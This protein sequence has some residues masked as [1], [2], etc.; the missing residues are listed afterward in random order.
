MDGSPDRLIADI[1]ERQYGYF[2]L[3]QC[4]AVGFTPD[5]RDARTRSGRWVVRYDRVYRIAGVPPSWRGELLAACWAAPGPA[6][7]S[8]RSAGKLRDLPGGRDDHLEITCHR[9]RRTRAA[10]LII[11]ES[12][13]LDATDLDVIAGIPTASIEQTLLGLAAVCHPDTV[14]MALD[15][16]LHRGSTTIEQLELFV[17]RKG[18]QGRDGIGVLRALV[19][20]LDP[21]A[22]VPESVKESQLKQL[23]RRNGFP[24]PEFQ[25]EIWHNGRFVARVDAAYPEHKIAIEYD[26]YQHHTGRDAIDRDNERRAKLSRINWETIAFTAVTLRRNGSEQLETLRTKLGFGVAVPS[27]TR[28]E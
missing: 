6:H 7:A 21:Q 26:S 23:L 1:A 4:E 9:W 14:E 12:K 10:G 11:H 18:K 15:R 17:G 19:R 28:P 5:R 27:I 16:A 3:A 25:Y 22:G 20:G 13:L 2:R 8:H 24:M